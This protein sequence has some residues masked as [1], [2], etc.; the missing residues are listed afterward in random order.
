LEL[1][2]SFSLFFWSNGVPLTICELLV[3][4]GV[5]ITYFVICFKKN[6]LFVIA[7]FAT[8]ALSFSCHMIL[9]YICCRLPSVLCIFTLKVGHKSDRHLNFVSVLCLVHSLENIFF[10]LD[11]HLSGV[12]LWWWTCTPSLSAIVTNCIARERDVTLSFLLVNMH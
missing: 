7:G 6:L 1:L 5:R 9:F 4:Y 2:W 11:F 12:G 10:R 3:F 8:F